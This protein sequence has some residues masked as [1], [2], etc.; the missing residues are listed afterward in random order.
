M[1]LEQLIREITDYVTAKISENQTVS[2]ED[3]P[4]TARLIALAALKYGDLSNLATKDYIFDLA[5]CA[6][7]TGLLKCTGNLTGNQVKQ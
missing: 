6:V 7:I 5:V 1:R 2:D 4:E 3:L